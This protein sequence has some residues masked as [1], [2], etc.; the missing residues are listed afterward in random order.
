MELYRTKNYDFGM[1]NNV[2]NP[3]PKKIYKGYWEK[4]LNTD[5]VCTCFS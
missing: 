5:S 1:V 3:H 2:I 4:V